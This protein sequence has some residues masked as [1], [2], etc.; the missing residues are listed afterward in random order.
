[1]RHLT[2]S[3][4]IFLSACAG[5][6]VMT[7]GQFQ[8][9]VKTEWLRGPTSERRMVLLEDFSYIDP[10]GTKWTAPK[11]SITDGASIPRP[12]WS[13]VGGPFE[14]QY[15]EAAV[16]HD[17]FCETRTAPHQDVH[18]IFY[19]AT[20]AAGVSEFYSKVL[21]S[22]VVWG[23]PKWSTGPSNCTGRCHGAIEQSQATSE[24]APLTEADVHSLE[25]WIRSKDP[26]LEEI[27][28]YVSKAASLARMRK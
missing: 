2:A 14:G 27:D 28:D 26:N 9:T 7:Y 12:L 25:N 10:K 3:L 8:G 18:R 5:A 15:R 19:Y 22:G 6:A 20:R 16:I 1:M 4:V 24:S 17:Y 11:G 21:Y 13:L 23:G